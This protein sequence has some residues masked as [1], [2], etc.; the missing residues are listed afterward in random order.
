V[1]VSPESTSDV[2]NVP[3]VVLIDEFSA[4]DVELNDNAYGVSFTLLTLIVKIFVNV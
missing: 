3:I 4:I 2:L 1:N